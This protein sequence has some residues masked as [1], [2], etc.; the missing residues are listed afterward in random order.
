MNAKV[1]DIL[2]KNIFGMC[3]ILKLSRSCPK[4]QD[5]KTRRK[6]PLRIQV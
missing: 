4:F 5:N 6:F 1:L 2:E 3:D